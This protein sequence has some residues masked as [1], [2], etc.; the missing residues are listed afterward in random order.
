MEME[1]YPARNPVGPRS[2]YL[3]ASACNSFHVKCAFSCL[4]AKVG[5]WILQLVKMKG[6]QRH[7]HEG[8]CH[9]SQNW[10]SLSK[11]RFDSLASAVYFWDY[12]YKSYMIQPVHITAFGERLKNG[13]LSTSVTMHFPNIFYPGET[14]HV[15]PTVL[16]SYITHE[17]KNPEFIAQPVMGSLSGLT[18]FTHHYNPEFNN[19]IDENSFQ[20]QETTFWEDAS[21]FP[22]QRLILLS[23]LCKNSLNG[24]PDMLVILI[25]M[26]NK[27]MCNIPNLPQ[28]PFLLSNKL[29]FVYC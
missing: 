25:C 15:Q 4:G 5:W 2:Q 9:S 14:T 13:H 24:C 28:Y 22:T 16:D 6:L 8:R 27:K 11:V 23:N 12:P 29:S 1:R 3:C 18:G 26:K 19:L 17:F 20:L 21:F 10:F 7:L